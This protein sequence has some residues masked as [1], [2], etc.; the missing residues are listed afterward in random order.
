[1]SNLQGGNSM[2]DSLLRQATQGGGSMIPQNLQSEI[3]NPHSS[4]SNSTRDRLRRKL[5][6]RRQEQNK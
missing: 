4:S 3:N 6:K 2:F 5:E 1:M